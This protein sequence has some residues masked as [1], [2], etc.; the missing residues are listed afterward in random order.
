MDKKLLNEYID[1]CELL[2]ETEL[3]LERLEGKIPTMTLDKVTGS[4]QEFP[5][6]ET[7]IQ[8]EGVVDVG[9]TSQAILAQKALLQERRRKAEAAKIQVENWMNEIPARMQR[10]IRYRY[11]HNLI[12]EE[13][14]DKMGRKATGNSVRMELERFFRKK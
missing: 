8:I 4:M 1:A 10:I 11:F 6:I 9:V 14:A 2:K 13:V 12:W 7:N 3:E 5:Y